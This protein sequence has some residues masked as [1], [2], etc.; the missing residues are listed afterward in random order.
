M[1]MSAQNTLVDLH[2]LLLAL[3]R[4]LVPL[5]RLRAF[6]FLIFSE[7]RSQIIPPDV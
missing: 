6:A 1:F 7:R 5:V 3:K 2:A 4:H